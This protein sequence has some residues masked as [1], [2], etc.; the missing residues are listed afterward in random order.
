MSVLKEM[1]FFGMV[2]SNLA[3][4]NNY[5]VESNLAVRPAKAPLL[6]GKPAL[7]CVLLHP[8]SR[9]NILQHF[10]NYATNE[11]MPSIHRSASA[12]AETMN[13]GKSP[14]RWSFRPSSGR[15][16]KSKSL[17]VQAAEISDHTQ[18]TSR[19]ADSVVIS[20][21]STPSKDLQSWSIRGKQSP[22]SVS[23]SQRDGT[24][25]NITSKSTPIRKS[26]SSSVYWENSSHHSEKADMSVHSSSQ[27]APSSFST[28]CLLPVE[29][30][31]STPSKRGLLVGRSMREVLEYDVIIPLTHQV[32]KDREERSLSKQWKTGFNFSA[33][34]CCISV[35]LALLCRST[36]PLYGILAVLFLEISW[37]LF[38]WTM[39]AFD[40]HDLRTNLKFLRAWTTFAINEGTDLVTHG[41]M[42]MIAPAIIAS[43]K[44]A[45][46][47]TKVLRQKTH[48]MNLHM[49][50]H[51]D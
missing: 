21:A 36:S 27:S 41:K 45:V 31:L 48:E 51:Q 50:M 49:S 37:I 6:V 18:S 38:K 35:Q 22:S 14:R 10:H 13:T 23:S 12:P 4:K 26:M 25:G 46:I 34:I 16:N 15:A 9:S 32:E 7:R 8:E 33:L 19:T 40:D 39:Y 47:G 11:T 30:E 42:R 44:A 29:E 1:S 24:T 20:P 43:Q 17:G 3:V 5:M 28:T 2:E